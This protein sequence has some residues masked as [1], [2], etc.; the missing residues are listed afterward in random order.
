MAYRTPNV[1]GKCKKCGTVKRAQVQATHV[2]YVLPP[3]YQATMKRQRYIHPLLVCECGA[4]IVAKEINGKYN[5]NKQCNPRC[6][7]A[8]GHQC[9]CSC[10]GEN[11]GAAHQPTN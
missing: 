10:G 11:H 2:D 7:G 4:A 6:M 3:E 9:E 8:T 1:I 5:P